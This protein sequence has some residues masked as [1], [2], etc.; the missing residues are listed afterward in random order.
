MN[1]DLIKSI[2]HNHQEL[3]DFDINIDF[4]NDSVNSIS[5]VPENS[6][7]L[8]RSYSDGDRI[9][10]FEFS[11]IIRLDT[12]ILDKKKNYHLLD[13]ITKSLMDFNLKSAGFEDFLLP[14]LSPMKINILNGP[15]L[16]EDNIHSSKYKLKCRLDCIYK[17]T[18]I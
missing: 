3:C 1:F 7:I 14:E 2:F 16:Y 13:S 4:L 12:D 10:G 18:L 15:V 17:N 9:Y 6:Y 11:V 5:I 8:L